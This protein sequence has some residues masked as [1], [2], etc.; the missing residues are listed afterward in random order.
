MD[1]II[2]VNKPSGMTFSD[3]VVR[4][5]GILKTRKV[6][7]TGTLDPDAAGVLPILIGKG[8]KLF[9]YVVKKR[10]IY[11]GEIT[12][13]TG[14]DTL[15]AN[16]KII[17]KSDVIPSGT[18]VIN[19]LN[20]FM[21]LIT[22]IPP[23]YSAI[24]YKGRKLYDL[25]REGVQVDI[26]SREVT[27]YNFDYI[28]QTSANSHLLSIECSAGTYIRTLFKDLAESLGSVAHL[29]FLLRTKAGDFKLDETHTI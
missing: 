13:G 5:K 28:K 16:G 7:H 20:G 6:G 29:S 15:D 3:V 2:S 24:Q 12:F 26:K 18:E 19:A 10:K 25:A 9:D 14:T 22:Q 1:G 17:N 23:M 8:T 21:G 11:I 27:I 4:L